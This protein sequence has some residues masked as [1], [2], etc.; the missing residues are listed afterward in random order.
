MQEMTHEEA[1]IETT[2]LVRC[3][4]TEYNGVTI[5]TGDHPEHG[6]VHIILPMSGSNLLIF[7]FA[8]H[9]F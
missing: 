4:I 7:P 3:E 5:Y 1:M 9:Q 6:S 8:L 2:K